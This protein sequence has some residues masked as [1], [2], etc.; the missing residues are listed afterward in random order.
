MRLSDGERDVCRELEA[1]AREAAEAW[2]DEMLATETAINDALADRAFAA[3]YSAYIV[4]HD[5][6][7][8]GPLLDRLEEIHGERPEMAEEELRNR[9]ALVA[10]S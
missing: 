1:D 7:A 5:G 2:R 9:R 6:D 3:L 4:D 10:W 8:L